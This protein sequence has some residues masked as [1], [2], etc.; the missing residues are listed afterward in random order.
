M[1]KEIIYLIT[2]FAI[3]GLLSGCH[4]AGPKGPADL[5]DAFDI[6][7]V[8]LAVLYFDTD[9]E[10]LR[11]LALDVLIIE[12]SQ[13]QEFTV[14][15]SE[16]LD[17]I[18][19][20]MGMSASDLVDESTRVQIGKALG[21]HIM[22]FGSIGSDSTRGYLARVE[23]REIFGGG[24]VQGKP[25]LKTIRALAEQMKAGLREGKSNRII[26]EISA[27]LCFYRGE[28][29]EKAGRTQDACQQYNRAIEIYPD[30]QEAKEAVK[31]LGCQG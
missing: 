26:R 12:F 2:F 15:E 30:H 17:E 10:E 22:C 18:L 29:H 1:R 5:D 25:E 7:P 8:T 4:S 9:N 14:V 27:T 16:K 23:T 21:A 13:M 28:A 20:E 24:V 19:D 31:R 11:N 6:E 3:L